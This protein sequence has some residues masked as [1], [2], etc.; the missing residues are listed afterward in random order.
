MG[1][2]GFIAYV[3]LLFIVAYSILIFLPEILFLTLLSMSV[4]V[5]WNK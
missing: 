5:Y 1:G 4:L 3:G 2:D